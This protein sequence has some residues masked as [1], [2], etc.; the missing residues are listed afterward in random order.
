MTPR[1]MP[2]DLEPQPQFWG[3]SGLASVTTQARVWLRIARY[4]LSPTLPLR[5]PYVLSGDGDPI[6]CLTAAAALKGYLSLQLPHS[7]LHLSGRCRRLTPTEREDAQARFLWRYPETRG[8]MG[9][10]FCLSLDKV[11]LDSGEATLQLDPYDFWVDRSWDP[12]ASPGQSCAW[13]KPAARIL[14]LRHRLPI[15]AET[16]RLLANDRYGLDLLAWSQGAFR[17]EWPQPASLE[18]VPERLTW[19]EEKL[20]KPI[21]ADHTNH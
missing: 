8:Q 17:V 1:W 7:A 14:E 4:L 6:L 21:G 12:V 18:Q 13:L 5:I 15:P 3:T 19:L 9:A 16:L 2:L 11:W 20:S 10:L